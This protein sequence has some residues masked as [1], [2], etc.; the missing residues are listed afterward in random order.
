MGRIPDRRSSKYVG[1]GKTLFFLSS[2]RTSDAKTTATVTYDAPL[3][4]TNQPLVNCPLGDI[5]TSPSYVPYIRSIVNEDGVE[6]LFRYGWEG[7]TGLQECVLKEI[8]VQHVNAPGSVPL[9]TYGYWNSGNYWGYRAI[10]TSAATPE[11]TENY[12]P[13]D[14]GSAY[15]TASVAGTTTVYQGGASECGYSVPSTSGPSE[16]LSVTWGT[17]GNCTGGDGYG[18]LRTVVDSAAG[19]GDGIAGSSSL[20]TKYWVKSAFPAFHQGRMS[21]TETASCSPSQ[22]CSLGSREYE[23]DQTGTAAPTWVKDKRGYFDLTPHVAPPGRP[24][25]TLPYEL[26]SVQRGSLSALNPSY[27]NC[28]GDRGDCEWY[29]YSYGPNDERRS[30]TVDRRGLLSGAMMSTRSFY[31]S[32]TNRLSRVVR[33]G[34]TRY[35]D[36]SQTVKYIATFYKTERSGTGNCDASSQPD[37]QLRTL[38]VHGPCFVTDPLYSL[39]CEATT[40]PLTQYTYWPST[41]TSFRAN[42]LKKVAQFPGGCSSAPVVTQYNQYDALGNATESVDSNGIVS[43]YVYVGSLMTA[44][45]VNNKTTSYGYDNGKLTWVRRPELNYEV[46][47]HRIGTSAECDVVNGTWTERV[48]WRAKSTTSTAAT[49]AEKVAYTYWPDGTLATESY[50]GGC[51]SNCTASSGEERRVLKHAADAHRRA[52]WDAWGGSAQYQATRSFDAEGAITGIGRPYNSPPAFCAGPGLGSGTSTRCALLDATPRG[53]VQSLSE[54]PLEGE[55]GTAAKFC[56]D[57]N[58]NVSRA[59]QGAPVGP[60]ACDIPVSAEPKASH[61]VYDDFGNVLETRSPNTSDGTGAQG[62]VR[63]EYDAI[64][65]VIK[66]QTEQQRASSQRAEF[67]YDMMGRLTASI[68]YWGP[69]PWTLYSQTWDEQGTPPSGCLT[70]NSKGRIRQVT[71]P[72]G[73]T[74]YGYDGFGH[75]TSEMRQRPGGSCGTTSSETTPNSSYTYT[76]NGN[77]STVTYPHGRQISYDYSSGYGLDDRPSSIQSKSWNGTSWSALGLVLNFISWEPY[78]GLRGYGIYSAGS[79]VATVDRLLGG[80]SSQVPATPCSVSVPSV[81]GGDL[82]GRLRSLRVSGPDSAVSGDIYKRTYTWKADQVSRIDSCYLGSASAQSEVFPASGAPLGFDQLLRLQRADGSGGGAYAQR[83]YSYDGRGNRLSMDIDA[84]GNKYSHTYSAAAQLP[85]QLNRVE[86]NNLT[87]NGNWNEFQ[88]D[89]DGRVTLK[90]WPGDSGGTPAFG[91][92]FNYVSDNAIGPGADTVY[93]SVGVNYSYYQYWY[94]AAGRRRRKDYPVAGV[95]DEFFYDLGHSMLEDRGNS[96]VLGGGDFALDEY[97]WLDGNPV[98]TYRSKFNSAWQRQPDGVG[99]CSRNGQSAPCGIQFPVV[100]HIGKPVL[101]LDGSR[102]IVGVGE[103]DNFGHVNRAQAWGASPSG[104]SA[105]PYN[106]AG[107]NAVIADFTQPTHGMSLQVRT[108]FTQ[109]DTEQF[110]GYLYDYAQVENGDTAAALGERLGGSHKGDYWSS[111]LAAPASGHMKVRFVADGISCPPDEPGCGCSTT[112]YGYKGVALREYEYQRYQDVARW[113]T[114]SSWKQT[115]SPA[116]GWEQ[117]AFNDSTWSP[118]VQET[119]YGGSPWGVGAS[120]PAGTPAKWIWYY[121][122]RASGDTSTVFFRKTFVASSTQATLMITSDD[123]FTAYLNGVQVATGNYW[124]ASVTTTLNLSPGSS[125]VLAVRVVN[126]GGAGGLIADINEPASPSWLPL[127]FP[128]QYHDAE[129]DL[130]ENWNRYYDPFIGGYLSPEPLLQDPRWVRRMAKRGYSTPTYA[131]AGNN[132]IHFVDPDG[133]QQCGTVTIVCNPY[134]GSCMCPLNQPNLPQPTPP[135]RP[136]YL[137]EPTPR[138]N[139]VCQADKKPEKSCDD[140]YDAC[141][142]AHEL[143]GWPSVANCVECTR[144]CKNSGGKWP[145]IN[146]TTSDR[147]AAPAGETGSG[148]G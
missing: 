10:L 3:D 14:L 72:L 34:S 117:L 2:I 111:W 95:T 8:R 147:L 75:I 86:R 69:T 74:W 137:P 87:G 142:D 129:T 128:G 112:S 20:Q 5:G 26:Q 140:H 100:D 61:F 29:T 22:S 124:P 144:Q 135:P 80:D 71:D 19:R 91:L 48:Q 12:T 43:T 77:L 58:G 78:G 65:N 132:P 21:R 42:K 28:Y 52:T 70:P 99:V 83:K 145:W 64:G 136:S 46:F 109:M 6:L 133:L 146:T 89:L 143:N 81:A 30:A 116:T 94:D 127:R 103:Y 16:N 110:C 56:Y 45:T 37:P 38:E 138:P 97:I 15:F 79:Y 36:G 121:D 118:S 122:S 66:R 9:A 60:Y 4:S 98:V 139:L 123:S 54:Y 148:R 39:A 76:D 18:F 125:Y 31:D 24:S 50:R 59:R 68:M 88:Y 119:A 134:T 40:Y 92:W 114:D 104:E 141:M 62:V 96:S 108:H 105:H 84:T 44:S 90:S 1:G 23:W 7:G 113:G 32:G 53:Q 33:E 57:S 120:F 82:T 41:E 11:R 67:T 130:F 63:M 17:A 27:P 85:D 51:Y 49:W 107:V 101:M 126:G 13:W 25:Y 115:L 106:W 47:C 102:R 55:P 131:Y 73:T 35:V 93:R